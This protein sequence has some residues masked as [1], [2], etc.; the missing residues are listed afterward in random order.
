MR[1]LG[2]AAVSAGLLLVPLASA[3][4]FGRAADIPIAGQ[5][6]S[7]VITDVTQD[8]LPD[9]VTGNAT[10]PGLSV[11]PGL[12]D[13]RFERRLDFGV[14]ISARTLAAGDFD[15]DGSVD[16]ALGGKNAVTIFAGLNAGLVRG[17]S[18]LVESPASLAVADLDS[19][20]NPDLVV[21]SSTRPVV[22]ILRGR[23]DMTFGQPADQPV[24]SPVT[25]VFV[26]DL[27]DDEVPDV[28]AAGDRVV[29]TLA[30]LGD[31]TF[32][33]YQE[34]A[35]PAVLRSVAGDDFDGDGYIDLVAAGGPN[36]VFVGLNPGDG[37]F[38]EFVA[39]TVG[40]TPVQIAVGD[41]D[42]AGESD[43]LAVN[44]GSNDI[45]IL[46]GDGSGAF[47]PQSRIKVG[48]IPTAVSVEDLNQDGTFDLAISNRGSRSVTV[49]LSGANAPQPVVCLVP[50]VV[51]RT[52]AVARRLVTRG[53]CAVASVRRRYSNRVRR[54]RVI[55]SKPLPGQR[56]PE[57]TPVLL[58]VSRGHK[59]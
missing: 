15:S 2:V 26:G 46:R 10:A 51:G 57:G 18:Y 39:Y 56:L 24:R 58:L 11:L 40:G 25:S 3:A 35:V 54:G 27:N 50:R 8:G 14:G 42:N 32:E 13:G 9:I 19:D 34:V 1:L 16:L 41:V 20:G 48:R 12:V 22:S 21:G 29:S 53:H 43:L 7:V 28:A 36:Q 23:G 17:E 49:L 4:F 55:A 45:S 37:T 59:R 44:R 52:L 38:P 47:L 33:P 5:P 6:L 30:G 31:G